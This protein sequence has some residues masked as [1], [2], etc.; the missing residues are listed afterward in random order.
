MPTPFGSEFS[1]L[2]MSLTA[3]QI[4]L[5]RFASRL[6][7]ALDTLGAP[8]QPLDRVRFFGDAIKQDA[9]N[10]SAMLNGFLMPD[11]DTL[12]NI[13]AATNRQP[14]YFLDDS[15]TQYPPETRL[16]K[17]LGT[18][19]NIVIRIPTSDSK[20]TLTAPDNEWS[21]MVA[22]HPMGFGV[23]PGDFVINCTPA[24]G[25]VSAIPNWLYL[26]WS[27]S[28]FEILKCV[29]V[30]PGRSTFTSMPS[31]KGGGMAK[32]L[33]LDS[34]G[35]RLAPDYIKDSGIEH[36]GVIAMTTRSSQVMARL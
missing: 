33:P 35:H 15:I 31:S 8:A 30:H 22:R 26:M 3:S 2:I 32:I 17:P 4:L 19:D 13:C 28:K 12:L 11:W 24:E 23:L 34:G 18:G 14:G 21:Y 9:G 20:G 16:V 5:K 36:L 25:T 1:K 6:N 29:D 10:V 27:A 7:R